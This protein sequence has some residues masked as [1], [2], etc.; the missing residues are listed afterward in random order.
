M[1]HI[2]LILL[3][4][5]ALAVVFTL[6][7]AAESGPEA[8]PSACAIDS[9]ASAD[10]LIARCSERIEASAT[11][12]AERVAA[13]IARA[14]AFDRR[15][16]T[17]RAIA[18]LDSAIALDPNSSLAFRLRGELVR[19]SGG[20][21]DRAVRDFNE[22]IRLDPGSAAAFGGRGNAF[23]N[24]RQ[25]DRAIEDYNEAVRLDPSF[26]QAF[27]DRG[28]AYYFKAD[29]QA[30]I[31]DF[32]EALR[33]DPTRAQTFTN[34]GAA[35]KKMGRND[36]ALADD[37]EAI[38]LDPTVP[39]YFD[40]R[41]LSYA[42]NREF[43]RAIADYDAAIRLKPRANFLTNRGDA[44]LYKG[45]YDRA[46]ADYDEALKLDPN[47]A[48]AY[49]NRGVV[50]RHNG[51]R[52]KALADYDAALRL[53]PRLDMVAES[54]KSLALEIER[55]GATMPLQAAAASGEAGASFDCATAR[56]AVEKAI[57][58]DP[59]L[60]QLDHDIADAYAQALKAAGAEGGRAVAALREQQRDFIATR[61]ASFGKSDYDLHTALQ[62][63]LQRLRA[64][65]AKSD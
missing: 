37:S 18:D 50:Y 62:I 33:L 30:A 39:E 60:R 5:A 65:L 34:R 64:A 16:D 61:N 53:N 26:A 38:R 58:A 44:Y 28:A 29:Y 12:P 51:N 32:D 13:L 2:V 21:L 63:R 23:N 3:S 54:R 43:D 8:A 15:H 10:D 20:D 19:H 57:C 24:L 52:A 17:T 55:I 46:L 47:F 14:T 56:R 59:S 40:N 31:R 11:T 22:A 35:Y 9:K 6:P 25:F 4:G 7:V 1:R 41:G 42:Q 36:R 27:S 48:L 45:D 49:A